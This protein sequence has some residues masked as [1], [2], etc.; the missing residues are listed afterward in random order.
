[1]SG[2]RTVAHMEPGVVEAH[3]IDYP[4]LVLGDRP[5]DDGVLVEVVS[6]NIRGKRTAHGARPYD[7]PRRR[8]AR[9]WWAA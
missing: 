6:A 2:S 3:V 9:G 4:V 1:M 7:H 5:G 8:S